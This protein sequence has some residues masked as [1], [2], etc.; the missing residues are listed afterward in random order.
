MKSWMEMKKEEKRKLSRVNE[1][2][3][4]QMTVATKVARA[5]RELEEHN[6]TL[7]LKLANAYEELEELQE[8]YYQL[9]NERKRENG[10]Y[11]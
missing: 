2:Y 4:D 11:G 7:M 1:E 10:H 5:V 3:I 6:R 8:A 9:L